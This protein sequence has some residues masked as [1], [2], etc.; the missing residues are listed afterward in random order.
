MFNRRARSSP[1]PGARGGRQ[2]RQEAHDPMRRP[3]MSRW[4]R[5]TSDSE[6]TRRL[7]PATMHPIAAQAFREAKQY[8]DPAATYRAAVECREQR[9]E[10]YARMWE[11]VTDAAA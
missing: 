5:S 11:R 4:K 9:A 3:A 7:D 1:S 8:T 10:G 2:A 6:Q